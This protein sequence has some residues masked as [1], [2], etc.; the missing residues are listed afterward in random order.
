MGFW[1]LWM[2]E[3]L[4]SNPAVELQCTLFCAA[5]GELIFM[6]YEHTDGVYRHISNSYLCV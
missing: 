2:H 6:K 1:L 3:V 5:A 4:D